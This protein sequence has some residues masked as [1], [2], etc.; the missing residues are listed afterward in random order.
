VNPNDKWFWLLAFQSAVRELFFSNPAPNS[1]WHLTK[2]H[3]RA[4]NN[5]LLE[6][7]CP[8]GG[9]EPTFAGRLLELVPE[10]YWEPPNI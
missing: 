4:I 10:T 5:L 9:L 6:Q 3:N 8:V 7:V 1:Q 2:S